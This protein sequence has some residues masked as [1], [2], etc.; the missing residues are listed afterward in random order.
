MG[1]RKE[2]RAMGRAIEAWHLGA[3]R[4]ADR[5]DRRSAVRNMVA[6]TEA[7]RG[8]MVESV[9]AVM[10]MSTRGLENFELGP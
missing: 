1:W 4:T 8:G 6:E 10:S 9:G 2:L 3:A 5:A 7:C